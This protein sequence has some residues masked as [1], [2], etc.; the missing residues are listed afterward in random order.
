MRETEGSRIVASFITPDLFR[1]LKTLARNNNREWFEKHKQSYIDDVRDPLCAFV[2][3]IGPK[4]RSVHPDVVADSRPN[5]GSLFRI[6]RDTRFS[7]DKT[8]YKTHAALRFRC[9]PK[10]SAAPGFYLGLEPGAVFA[11]CG[12]WHPQNQTLQLLRNAIDADQ[13]GWRRASKVGLD[14]V[15]MYKRMPGGFDADHPLEFDLRRKSFTASVGFTEKQACAGAFPAKFIQTCRRF[16]PLVN[17]LD[18]A[19][20]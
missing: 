3:V 5:G 7:K 17:F 15:E 2:E 13:P 12:I 16:K 4:L 19:V 6:H 11:A 10:D 8:P 20:R 9:G 1:F 18:G 14:D